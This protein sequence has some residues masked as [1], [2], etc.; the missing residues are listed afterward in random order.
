[1]TDNGKGILADWDA[2]DEAIV[3]V[4]GHVISDALRGHKRTGIPIAVWDRDQ[5]RAVIVP[6]EEI[7]VPDDLPT[8]GNGTGTAD[9]CYI[10]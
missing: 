8:K 1:M 5:N 7:V 6:P 10:N 4:M 2:D 9:P 3:D